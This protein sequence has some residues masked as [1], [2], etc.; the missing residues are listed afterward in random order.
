MISPVATVVVFLDTGNVTMTTTA[1]ISATKKGVSLNP[2]TLKV[3]KQR[4]VGQKSCTGLHLSHVKK[5][6]LTLHIF[7]PTGFADPP[8]SQPDPTIATT[9]PAPMCTWGSWGEWSEC[10]TGCGAGQR[11]R[12]RSCL[13][14]DASQC[15]GESIEYEMCELTTCMPE[16]GTTLSTPLLKISTFWKKPTV[17]WPNPN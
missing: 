2:F 15:E 9:A 12:T 3:L 11:Q 10:N 17:D 4:A 1:E 14:A 5:D 8:T 7:K 16:A 6:H 13:C